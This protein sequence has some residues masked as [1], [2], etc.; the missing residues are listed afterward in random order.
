MKLTISCLSGSMVHSS[1]AMLCA[2]SSR[3]SSLSTG[4]SDTSVMTAV[5]VLANVRMFVALS[6]ACT[7]PSDAASFASGVM[8]CTERKSRSRCSSAARAASGLLSGTADLGRPVPR[9][10]DSSRTNTVAAAASAASM[11]GAAAAVRTSAA[12]DCSRSSA[13]PAQATTWLGS[14]SS[15][16]KLSSRRRRSPIGASSVTNAAPTAATS[17]SALLK[18][19]IGV[20]CRKSLRTT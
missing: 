16:S 8:H 3:C 4:D 11:C 19:A 17:Q 2:T 18:A 10:R 1:V 6:S 20:C 13:L 14:S 15:S 12:R 5:T 9:R 7:W